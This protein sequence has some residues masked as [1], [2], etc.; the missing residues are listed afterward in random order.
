MSKFCSNCGKEIDEKAVICV[1]CGAATNNVVQTTATQKQTGKGTG[2]ASMVLGI[3]GTWNSVGSLF[4][5]ICFV[6]AGEYLLPEEKLALGLIF[7]M[8]P[9]ILLTIGL[10]LGF[11]SRSKIKNGINLTGLL[12]NFISLAMCILSILMLCLI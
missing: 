7:L 3:V 10:I 11:S 4:I 1:G 5:F 2:I 12:L 8:I 6:I 9:I